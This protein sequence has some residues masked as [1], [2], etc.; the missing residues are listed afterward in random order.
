MTKYSKR[1]KSAADLIEKE[2]KYLLL[3]AMDIIKNFPPLKFVETVEMSVRLGVDP[4]KSDQM[5][6]GTVALPHG[7]GK[8]V[9]VLVF[10]KGEQVKEAQEA[11]AD[12]VGLEELVTK[13][14]GGW[15]DFD[16]AI[17]TPDVMRD[18]GKMGRVLGPRGLMPSPKA[19]TVTQA[20]GQAIKEVKAGKIEFK[21]DKTGNVHVPVGRASFTKEDLFDNAAAVIDALQRARPATAKGLYFKG[22]TLS[23]TMGPGITLDIKEIISS[24]KM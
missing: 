22:C 18:I 3:E 12:Y 4:R 9:R 13:I 6:R 23:T 17:A 21:T 24:L 11:G 8:E 19:G 15:F 14:N 5:V 10:A 1:Y 16:V 2:K 20:V 7:T